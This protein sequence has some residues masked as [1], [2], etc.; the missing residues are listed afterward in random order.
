MLIGVERLPGVNKRLGINRVLREQTLGNLEYCL[1]RNMFASKGRNPFYKRLARRQLHKLSRWTL[2]ALV[3]ARTAI[4]LEREMSM[5]E[6]PLSLA[7]FGQLLQAQFS[8]A[9]NSME[10]QAFVVTGEQTE[11]VGDVAL[12]QW[13]PEL[14]MLTAQ[15]QALQDELKSRW[16]IGNAQIPD[17]GLSFGDETGA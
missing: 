11:M 3:L 2:A 4:R 6:D 14:R 16:L 13:I 12:R 1:N 8:D 17:G 7:A 9:W 15:H 5:L 10:K